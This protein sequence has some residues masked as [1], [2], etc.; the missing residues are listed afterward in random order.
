MSD[1]EIYYRARSTCARFYRCVTILCLYCKLTVVNG[2]SF[3]SPITICVPI[4]KSRYY[5]FQYKW[6]SDVCGALCGGVGVA[7]QWAVVAAHAG[8][9]A[10]TGARTRQ[11]THT[12][13]TGRRWPSTPGTL[14]QPQDSNAVSGYS[15]YDVILLTAY[16]FVFLSCNTYYNKILLILFSLCIGK[17]KWKCCSHDVSVFTEWRLEHCDCWTTH[18]WKLHL[19]ILWD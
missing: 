13:C 11:E 2:H 3:F 6:V 15:R 10:H 17:K 9:H 16:I 5:T 7:V 19:H 1:C 18:G 14:C 12:S 8:R 4:L